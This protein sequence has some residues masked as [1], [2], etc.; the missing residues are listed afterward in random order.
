MKAFNESQRQQIAG[1]G[2]ILLFDGE[3]DPD[4]SGSH[5][6]HKQTDILTPNFK[7]RSRL[8]SIS[9]SGIWEFVVRY[10]GATVPD[11]HGVS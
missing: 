6:E 8:P 9:A 1:A 5:D 11:S 10:S 3:V 4:L 2:L 7:P